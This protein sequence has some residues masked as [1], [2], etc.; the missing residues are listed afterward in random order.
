MKHY[1]IYEKV[2]VIK[3]MHTS[4]YFICVS[5]V[6]SIVQGNTANQPYQTSDGGEI[7]NINLTFSKEAF[8]ATPD[9]PGWVRNFFYKF[10]F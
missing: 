6:I 3:S 7:E 9:L 2:L 4:L 5:V 8:T 10:L 1:K